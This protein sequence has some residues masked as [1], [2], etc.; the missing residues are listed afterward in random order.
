MPFKQQIERTER[1]LIELGFLR[2]FLVQ[3]FHALDHILIT[4]AYKLN[5]VNHPF[6]LG[7]MYSD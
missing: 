2:W 1:K 6:G 3:E 4:A 7:E 5:I